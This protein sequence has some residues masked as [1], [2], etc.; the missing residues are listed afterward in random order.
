MK[1]YTIRTLI[2]D[3]KIFNQLRVEYR[4]ARK[5]GGHI[6]PSDGCSETWLR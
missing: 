4:Q 3:A 2:H 1:R 5:T 6:P